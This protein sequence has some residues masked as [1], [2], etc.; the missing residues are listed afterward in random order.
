MEAPWAH[1]HL[2]LSPQ[3][4][5]CGGHLARRLA[6]QKMLAF[7]HGRLLSA[8]SALGRET[9]MGLLWGH[10][11]WG[12]QHVLSS[13]SPWSALGLPVATQILRV[14][15]CERKMARGSK[16]TRKDVP[17]P[18]LGQGALMRAAAWLAVLKPERGL[19]L[20]A[21]FHLS[22]RAGP[23]I[24]PLHLR[25]D[26]WEAQERAP[27]TGGCSRWAALQ[28]DPAVLS[29]LPL[30][31]Q[32]SLS[33]AEGHHQPLWPPSLASY[34]GLVTGLWSREF[35]SSGP[36]KGGFSC[37]LGTSLSSSLSEA[38]L[39]RKSRCFQLSEASAVPGL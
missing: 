17:V 38:E 4:G 18:G 30:L 10:G 33:K 23:R 25:S 6:P 29:R 3:M 26:L 1:G 15:P 2:V 21:P 24:E 16:V 35:G 19:R 39:R 14:S 9:V 31:E 22:S 11:A 27:E 13:T 36:G 32:K 34:L 12:R 7:D 28:Q 5:T 20:W 37:T 8:H